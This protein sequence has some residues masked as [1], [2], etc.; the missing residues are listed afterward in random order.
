MTR[1]IIFRHG[2]RY[3]TGEASGD[4]PLTREGI[5]TTRNSAVKLRME[6]IQKHVEKIDLAIVSGSI[7]GAQTFSILWT[8]LLTAFTESPLPI[9]LYDMSKD[10][11]STAEEDARWKVFYSQMKETH[12]AAKALVGEKEAYLRSA[13]ARGLIESCVH[14]TVNRIRAGV[15]DGAQNIL[16]VTHAPHDALIAEAVTSVPCSQC[17]EVGTYRIV[18]F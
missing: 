4:G 5:E 2:K 18:E 11:F 17:L 9:V 10:Y 12:E 16:L 3:I 13:L 1:L 7:R 8:V 15:W 6:L 14:R